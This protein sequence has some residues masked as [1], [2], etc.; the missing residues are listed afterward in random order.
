MRAPAARRDDDGSVLGGVCRRL[1]KL[2]RWVG[3]AIADGEWYRAHRHAHRVSASDGDANGRAGEH[4]DGNRDRG[5]HADGNGGSAADSDGDRRRRTGVR[6]GGV[7]SRR[8]RG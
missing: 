2:D 1:W 5:E 3:Y 4:G 6:F 8:R 7:A